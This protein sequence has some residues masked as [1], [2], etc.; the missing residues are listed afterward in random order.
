MKKLLVAVCVMVCSNLLWAESPSCEFDADAAD[1]PDFIQKIKD[2]EN[3]AIKLY[4][5]SGGILGKGE[6]VQLYDQG[7]TVD[8]SGIV[9]RPIVAPGSLNHHPGVRY[10]AREYYSLRTDGTFEET[11]IFAMQKLHGQMAQYCSEGW[12]KEKEWSEPTPTK[13]GDFYLYYQFSCSTKP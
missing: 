12:L 1:S 11:I 7:T 8:A 5:I 13:N 2:C 4:D 9:E 10:V 6:A 3:K